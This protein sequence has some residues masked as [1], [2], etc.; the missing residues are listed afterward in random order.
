MEELEHRISFSGYFVFFTHLMDLKSFIFVYTAK[1]ESY[2]I[3]YFDIIDCFLHYLLQ[4]LE[5][6]I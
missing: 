5:K 6:R 3:N 1:K 4:V 2:S